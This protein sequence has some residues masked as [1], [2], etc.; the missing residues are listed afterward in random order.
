LINMSLNK[1]G[2][3]D[4]SERAGFGCCEKTARLLCH[5]CRNDLSTVRNLISIRAPFAKNAMELSSSMEGRIT[6]LSMAYNRFALQDNHAL[7]LHGLANDI[8]KHALAL[9]LNGHHLTNRLPQM[10]IGLRLASPLAMWLYEIL[11]N[12][13][14]H[15]SGDNDRAEV[16]LNGELGSKELMVNVMDQGPGLAAGFDLCNQARAGLKVAQAVSEFDLKAKMELIPT[17]P[18]LCVQLMVPLEEINCLNNM[19]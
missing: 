11:G 18:G 7:T 17:A 10:E 14:T 16:E 19:S 8:S 1:P 9:T 12:A 2:D 13:I 6:A 15:G 3:H 4:G 5:R